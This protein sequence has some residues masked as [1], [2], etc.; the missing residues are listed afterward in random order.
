MAPSMQWQ[1]HSF[2]QLDSHTLYDILKLRVDVFVVEQCC[3]YPEL[4]ELDRQADT[5]HIYGYQQQQLAAYL[6]CLA[7]GVVYDNYAAIGRVVT[8]AE[9]RGQG[10]GHQLI[11]Q[12][13]EAC[14]KHWP[15]QHIKL[16]AQA[17]LQDYYRQH[18]FSPVGEIYL[19]DNIEHITMVHQPP[20]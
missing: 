6:R 4:D 11:E 18:N 5:L 9:F 14:Q 7:P 2:N 8:A 12:G 19:E 16:S 17:H 15:Q 13:I 3:Y 20:A 10:L 1:Q